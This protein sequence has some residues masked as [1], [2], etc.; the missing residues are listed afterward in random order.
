MLFSPVCGSGPLVIRRMLH[1][2]T[3]AM[4]LIFFFEREFLQLDPRASVVV[5]VVVT[6]HLQPPLQL[7]RQA[8]AVQAA[9]H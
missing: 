6:E 1:S 8:V 5:V 9:R 7:P 2:C 3:G 4:K